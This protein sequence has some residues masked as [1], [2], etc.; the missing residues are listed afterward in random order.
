MPRHPLV[1]RK[2][3]GLSL[4]LGGIASMITQFEVIAVFA[5]FAAGLCVVIS[6]TL[7]AKLSERTSVQTGA[8][9]NYLVGLALS[10]PVFLL[11]GRGE[12]HL[13]EFSFSHDWYI[14]LGGIVGVCVVLLSNYTALRISAFYLTLL[15]FVGQ[16]F[17]GVLIDAI[18]SGALSSRNLFG[19]ILVA[20][21][22]AV[23]LILDNKGYQPSPK[24]GV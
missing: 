2:L 13:S 16:V 4:I 23:N 18:L 12:I 1:G 10:I 20:A 3:I 11:L 24:Q 19:G 7:N 15:V 22:L 21:C 14:Y 6:R 17:S 5:S 8:F 9:Y